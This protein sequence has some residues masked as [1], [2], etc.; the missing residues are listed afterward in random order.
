MRLGGSGFRKRALRIIFVIKPLPLQVA[1]L[2][3]IAIYYDQF[4]YARARHRSGLKAPKRAT[5][6]NRY[7]GMH[8]LLLPTLAKTLETDLARVTFPLVRSHTT[9]W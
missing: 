4:P 7:G 1:R 9:R 6:H 8:E 2:Q 3:V 5:A